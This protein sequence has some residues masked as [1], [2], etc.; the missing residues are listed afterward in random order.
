MDP[1]AESDLEPASL[2]YLIHHVFLVPKL[3]ASSP[4][5]VSHDSALLR[6][7]GEALEA[8]KPHMGKDGN[9][10]INSIQGMINAMEYVMDDQGGIHKL[11][12][13]EQ[14]KK[15]DKSGMSLRYPLTSLSESYKF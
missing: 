11:K 7:L 3:P 6:C 1:D 12:F 2:D 9:G 8:F 14:L 5:S 10:A 13:K 15:L 4:D